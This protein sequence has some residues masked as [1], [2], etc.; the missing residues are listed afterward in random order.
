M[1]RAEKG[2]SKSA[3]LVALVAW[4][5]PSAGH[6]LLGR[7]GRAVVFALVVLT[8]FAVGAALGGNLYRPVAGQPLSLFAALGAMGAGLPYFL[9]RVGAGYEGDPT[10]PGYEI[11]T[12]FLLSAG[13]MNILLVL[14]ALDIA[15]GRKE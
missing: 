12:V 8:S 9:L 15:G 10:G 3:A 11:G 14:D 5:V 7:R 4:A 1:S 2:S 13:L 6:L